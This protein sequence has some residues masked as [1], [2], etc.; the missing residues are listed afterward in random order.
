MIIILLII[1]LACA[2]LAMYWLTDKFRVRRRLKVNFEGPGIGEAL[3]VKGANM[4]WSTVKVTF[5][6]TQPDGML[7]LNYGPILKG[8]GSGGGD[9]DPYIIIYLRQGYL[10]T[11][12]NAETF[13][14]EKLSEQPMSDGQKHTVELSIDTSNAK[15]TTKVDKEENLTH[16]FRS[17]N[18][19]LGTQVLIGYINNKVRTLYGAEDYFFKP[20]KGCFYL[21]ELYGE[22]NLLLRLENLIFGGQVKKIYYNEQKST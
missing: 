4:N 1:G 3:N 2:L 7:Y 15:A 16:L 22:G 9:I 13:V 10:Y 8:V 21:F 11:Y 18:E 5:S 19:A 14:D 17:G 20:F 6:T 12:I